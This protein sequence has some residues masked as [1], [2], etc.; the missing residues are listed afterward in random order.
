MNLSQSKVET[1]TVAAKSEECG[2]C[3]YLRQ[4]CEKEHYPKALYVGVCKNVS[5]ATASSFKWVK[6]N[7]KGLEVIFIFT[8]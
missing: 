1:Y 4:S 7:F 8:L 3:K 5:D 2:A 6:A